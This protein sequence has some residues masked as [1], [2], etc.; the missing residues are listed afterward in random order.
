MAGRGGTA[1]QRQ[2]ALDKEGGMAAAEPRFATG[3]CLLRR[4]P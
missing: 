3:D 2:V 4:Y 1:S